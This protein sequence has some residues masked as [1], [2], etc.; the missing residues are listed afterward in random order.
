MTGVTGSRGRDMAAMLAGGSDAIVTGLTVTCNSLMGETGYIPVVRGV[1]GI[2]GGRSC[3]VAAVF[4][5]GCDAIVAG[6]TGA[7]D[8]LMGETG[9]IPVACAVA[10]IALAIGAYVLIVFARGGVAI[11]ATLAGAHNRDM[12]YPAHPSPAERGVA[13]FT[14]VAGHDMRRRFTDRLVSVMTFKTISADAAM[15]E[16]RQTPVGGGMAIIT[17]VIGLYMIGILAGGLGIV[18]ASVT[19]CGCADKDTAEVA[20]VALNLPMPAS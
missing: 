5:G 18:V 17:L 2:A 16:T 9:Y 12:I 4:A 15:V 14:G 8:S 13:Q 1:A 10:G 6:R 7:C 19:A 11:V 20:A 3:N